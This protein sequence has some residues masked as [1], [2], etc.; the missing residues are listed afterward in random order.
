MSID[1]RGTRWGEN[2]HLI[3]DALDPLNHFRDRILI[4]A[5]AGFANGI[6]N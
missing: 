6:Y 2:A 1:G 5:L 3:A 4:H